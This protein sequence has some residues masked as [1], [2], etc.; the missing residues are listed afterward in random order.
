MIWVDNKKL[1][2]EFTNDDGSIYRLYTIG[3]LAEAVGKS[4]A[5]I[6]RWITDGVI[7]AETWRTEVIQ[8]NL[9]DTGLRL[10][11]K[12]QIDALVRLSV[13]E[14]VYGTTR[15]NTAGFKDKVWALWKT[16]GW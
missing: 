7:P 16:K 11:S 13:E 9:G 1:Y 6:R 10:W 4:V 14:R 2:R 15:R 3:A 8:R 12:E 5:A